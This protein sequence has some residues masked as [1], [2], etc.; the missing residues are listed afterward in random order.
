L[1][2]P[3][4]VDGCAYSVGDPQPIETLLREG[5]LSPETYEDCVGRGITT[6]CAGGPS[7]VDMTASARARAIASA[8]LSPGAIDSVVVADQA[9]DCAAFCAGIEAS[10]WPVTFRPA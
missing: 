8:G 6:Y 5:V 4:Y 2:S 7:I 1:P 3:I 9:S 10:S